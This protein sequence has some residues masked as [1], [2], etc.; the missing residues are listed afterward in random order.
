M[1]KRPI[2]A[3]VKPRHKDEPVEKMIKRFS[4]KVKKERIVEKVIAKQRYEKPSAKRK[5]EAQRK[6]KVLEKIRLEQENK[7][8]GN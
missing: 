2:N 1:S 8:K 3:E 5:R 7:L 6:K 4:K